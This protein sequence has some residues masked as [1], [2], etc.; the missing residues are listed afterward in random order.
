MIGCAEIESMRI[1]RLGSAVFEAAVE[2]AYSVFVF[3]LVWKATH[4]ED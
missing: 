2:L 4:E 1:R 3:I